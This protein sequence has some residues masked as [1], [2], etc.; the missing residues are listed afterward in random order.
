MGGIDSQGN[1]KQSVTFSLSGTEMWSEGEVE[2]AD[3]EEEEEEEEEEGE[4]ELG[5][6]MFSAWPGSDFIQLMLVITCMNCPCLGKAILL[7]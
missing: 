4:E 6:T 3:E 7:E 5:I 1:K 2:V